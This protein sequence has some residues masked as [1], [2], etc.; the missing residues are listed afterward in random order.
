MPSAQR[1]S[2]SQE[3]GQL[4]AGVNLSGTTVHVVHEDGCRDLDGC[5]EVPIQPLYFH[6]QYIYPVE[7]RLQLEYAFSLNFGVEL[8][9]PFRAV[10]TTIEYT[11]ENGAPYEPL[12]PDV[13]HRDETVLGPSD[14]WLLGRVG[15]LFDGYWLAL[16]AGVSIPLGRTEEDPFALGDQGLRHQHIQLGSGTFDPVGILEASKRFEPVELQL[17]TQG[18]AALYDNAHGYRAPWKVHGGL[19][20]TLGKPD[21]LRGLLGVEAFHEAAE[22]WQG[23]VRQDGS[24][25]RTELLA[26]LGVFTR[27]GETEFSLNLRVPFYRE[28]VVGDEPPGSLSSPLIVS[29]GVSR[30]FALLE[31]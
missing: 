20:A 14:P 31:E 27:W 25:G 6:D 21:G 30:S 18:Q 23:V 26:A 12:D 8:Q 11:D 15:D 29:L 13:H 24:L 28:I 7:L 19:S 22:R 16:R 9:A 3:G 5:E 2:G 17:F 10:T 1:G 4:R